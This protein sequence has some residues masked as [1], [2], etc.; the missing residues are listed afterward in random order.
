[1]EQ[2]A[3]PASQKARDRKLVP[4]RLTWQDRLFGPFR[5]GRGQVLRSHGN[6]RLTR[7]IGR[8]GMGEVWQA[9]VIGLAAFSKLV[10]IKRVRKKRLGDRRYLEMLADEARLVANLTHP[11]IVQVHHLFRSGK[12][13]C[14]A[15][16]FVYGVTFLQIMERLQQLEREM[17]VDVACYVVA[18]ICSGLYYAHMK[19]SRSGVHLGI[20]HR[21]ICPSNILISYRG[22]PKI[23][24]FGVAKAKTSKVDDENDTVWG[25]YPYMAP[26][27]VNRLGTD[28]RSDVYSLGLVL[29]EA[30]SGKLAHHAESTRTLQTILDQEQRTSLSLLPHRPALPQR[31]SQI[32]LRATHQDPDRRY[33]TAQEFGQDVESFM[34]ENFLFPGEERLADFL[35]TLF[36][37]AA[38]H[39]WW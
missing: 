32:I 31:I 29:F 15:M 4:G 11:H 9:E 23:T 1:M 6:Y 38:R 10:A 20:V 30:L 3:R 14:I 24:D 19:R 22:V 5:R 16:E 18:R 28:S 7:L 2:E 25:K 39:R 13:V 17:P 27:A 21:D 26:E 36:P 37:D 34:V 35:A 8:G 33:R 12:D